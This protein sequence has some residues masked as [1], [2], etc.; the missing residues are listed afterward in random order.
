MLLRKSLLKEKTSSLPT[1]VSGGEPRPLNAR[2]GWVSIPSPFNL[3]FGAKGDSSLCE[4]NSL[5]KDGREGEEPVTLSVV[6]ELVHPIKEID[7]SPK[8]GTC[9]GFATLGSH[10]IGS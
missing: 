8:G 3:N 10:S 5:S 6:V 7:Y 2:G 4:E 9:A 1:T